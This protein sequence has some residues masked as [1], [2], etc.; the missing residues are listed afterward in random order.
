VNLEILAPLVRAVAG[1]FAVPEVLFE[2]PRDEKSIRK[3]LQ[4]AGAE[5]SNE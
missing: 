1:H 2:L 3:L 5:R 4:A